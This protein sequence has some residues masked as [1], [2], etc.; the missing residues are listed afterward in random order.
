VLVRSQLVHR[1]RA[2]AAAHRS[3]TQEAHAELL[4]ADVLD[5][6]L[7]DA[8]L[9]AIDGIERFEARGQID[10][11]AQ[12]GIR[13]A[14]RPADV[15]D[16]RRAGVDA[17]A[18]VLRR[19]PGLLPALIQSGQCALHIQRRRARVAGMIGVVQRGVPEGHDRVADELVDGA[20]MLH[21]HCAHRAQVLGHDAHQDCRRSRFGKRREVVQVGQ[22]D[23]DRAL[24]GRTVLRPATPGNLTRQ[25]GWHDR[26]QRRAQRPAP[27]PLDQ[28]PVR[29]EGDHGYQVRDKVYWRQARRPEQAGNRSADQTERQRHQ[30]RAQEFEDQQAAHQG[31]ERGHV[32]NSRIHARTWRTQ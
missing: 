5:R 9:G 20:T 2:L 25:R 28:R 17:D 3:V 10:R 16:R 24:L 1:D 19:Q 29:D 11:V 14:Q 30:A 8:D 22:Q 6:R 12:C 23:T 4:A 18:H 27:A 31:E 7:G 32:G 26:V 21:D 13:E 15:A